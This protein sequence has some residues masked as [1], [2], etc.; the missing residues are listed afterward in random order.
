M[1]PTPK[2]DYQGPG[3]TEWHPLDIVVDRVH[4]RVWSI[5]GPSEED[6]KMAALREALREAARPR[7]MAEML[8]LTFGERVPPRRP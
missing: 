1:W 8:A 6:K 4:H 7:N 3:E 2:T 5:P